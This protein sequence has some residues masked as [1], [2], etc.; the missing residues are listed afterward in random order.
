MPDIDRPFK[1]PG[2][3][4]TPIL[5]VVFCVYL[6]CALPIVTWVRFIVWLI[7]GGL[8]YFGYGAKH[9]ALNKIKDKDTNLTI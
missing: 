2:V 7:L 3:P 5:T 4:F 8:I 9:S 1:C 6:M